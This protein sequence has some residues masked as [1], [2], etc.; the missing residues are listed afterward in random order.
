VNDPSFQFDA[1]PHALADFS[2]IRR[3]AR[4]KIDVRIKITVKTSQGLTTAMFGRG[5]DISEGGMVAHIPTPLRI[6]EKV[7]LELTFP[8][9]T[10]TV[11]LQAA[12]R[13][14][15]GFRF[16]L[17]FMGLEDAVRTMIIQI[18]KLLSPVQ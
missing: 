6:G 17:E 14:S 1:Q 4:Y 11:R 7:Q 15:D 12:V 5:S 2:E 16:G 18:C 3:W 9:A 8:G 13:N 10:Q